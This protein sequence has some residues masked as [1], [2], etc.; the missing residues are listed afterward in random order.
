MLKEDTVT[1]LRSQER[2]KLLQAQLMTACDLA[3]CTK[4]WDI[5]RRVA[6]LVTTEFFNQVNETTVHTQF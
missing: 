2:R 5:Q 4:Q 1:H 6:Y 3:A